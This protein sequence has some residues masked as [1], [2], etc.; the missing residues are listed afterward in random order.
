MSLALRLGTVGASPPLRRTQA[1]DEAMVEERIKD[2]A[3]TWYELIR[4]ATIGSLSPSETRERVNC[5]ARRAV[6][7][8]REGEDC[9]RG[10]VDALASELLSLQLSPEVLGKL[11]QA[12]M[13]ALGGQQSP[14][15]RPERLT[16]DLTSALLKQSKAAI[17]EQQEETRRAYASALR[18]AERELHVK[19]AAVESSIT[20]V[21]LWTPNGEMTYVNPAFLAMWGWDRQEEVLGRHVSSLWTKHPPF[22]AIRTSIEQAGGWIG[23]LRAIRPD[24]Q[25]FTVMLAASAVEPTESMPPFVIGSFVDM[26]YRE[27]LSAMLWRRVDRLK[28]IQRVDRGI[29]AARSPEE[30]AQAALKHIRQLIPCARASVA[31]FEPGDERAEFLAAV[32]RSAYADEMEHGIP[33]AGFEE[34]LEKLSRDEVHI[35]EDLRRLPLPTSTHERLEHRRAHAMVSV[36]LRCE[37]QFLGALNLAF[38]SRDRLSDRHISIARE[39]A[40]SLAVAIRHAQLDQAISRHKERLQDL[41]ARLAEADEAERR[42]LARDLHDQIGQKLTALG[43]N[44]NVIKARLGPQG[45]PEL[46]T[47]L[48]DSLDL[49]KETT[50]RVRR[51]IADLRPPMLDDYG[52]LPTLRWCGEQLAL[53]TEVEV[54]IHGEEPIQRLP[55]SMEDTL[56]RIAQEALTNVAKHAEASRAVIALSETEEGVRLIVS[57]DGVGFDEEQIDQ[58]AHWGLLTMIERAESVGGCCRIESDPGEGT[59]VI[60]EVTR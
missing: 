21:A 56:V 26:T 52:L 7:L 6:D 29:L 22:D 8:V 37:G 11:Q 45:S 31:L 58:T 42:R 54:A 46:T 18:R 55:P 27:Q 53:R 10:A 40:D 43:I 34:S 13:E 30:I 41:T 2:I 59:Q 35:I 19:G 3:D 44:L 1:R 57:D 60:A 33:L 9:G 16:A 32:P 12:L 4:P 48:D 14:G 15:L 51:V 17:L 38:T 25:E 23:K 49:L 24:G 5:L 50:D 47:R 28:A 39:V 20:A 36:P